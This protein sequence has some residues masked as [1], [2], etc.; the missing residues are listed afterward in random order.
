MGPAANEVYAARPLTQSRPFMLLVMAGIVLL[1][2]LAML[3]PI[4]NMN[5]LVL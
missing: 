4:L 3:L 2:M 1:I 5:A